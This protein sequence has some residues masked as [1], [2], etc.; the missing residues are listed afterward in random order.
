[1]ELPL[2]SYEQLSEDYLRI[3]RAITFL[4]KH[5]DEQPSLK[6]MAASAALSEFHFHRLFTRWVG[7]SPKRFMQYLTKEHAKQLLAGSEN[8]LDVT[9]ATGLSSPGRLHDLFVSCEAVTPG[10]FKRR[11]EGLHIVYGFHPS[12]FGECLLAL[13][14]RGICSLAFVL[15]GGLEGGL[16][17]GL[18][19]GR[20]GVLAALKKQWA[21]AHLSE[22]PRATGPFVGRIF[23]IFQ[24]QEATPLRLYLQGTN[25][26]IKVWEALLRIPPGY[27]V[28][29]EDIAVQIGMPRA[30]RA[31]GNA[32]AR[33]PIPVIIPCH[34]VIHKGGDFGGYSMGTARKKAILGWEA[35]QIDL[36]PQLVEG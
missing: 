21:G 18:G 35:A 8:L 4:E 10:E 36:R 19:G 15:E 25:F 29:Y 17:G 6:A 1:M 13:T 9:Y 3:E 2:I 26:Q 7:I 11:G 28:S 31:V 27:V 33:N 14:E 16:G 22:D 23:R 30:A 34:R 12:P 5:F 20:E 24:G 32:I